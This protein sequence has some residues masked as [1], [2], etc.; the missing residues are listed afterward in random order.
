M[1]FYDTEDG[2]N[3]YLDLAEG[4][5]GRS[6]IRALA[7]FLPKGAT[8]LE[9][10]MGPGVDLDILAHDYRA[11]GSDLSQLFLDRYRAMHSDADL[12]RLDAITLNT[13]RRFDAIYSNKV[14][15]HLSSDQLPQ[16]RVLNPGGLVLH[17]LWWGDK[18]DEWME[19]LRFTYYTESVLSD[20]FASAGFELLSVQRYEEME[21]SDSVYVIAR[22]AS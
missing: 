7:E 4:Y 9:I 14:L 5:D 19:G 22:S 3:T 11:T 13:E 16:A 8:V 18:D 12:L 17:S 1:G 15:H 20:I 21:P 6:L 2:I 10:G